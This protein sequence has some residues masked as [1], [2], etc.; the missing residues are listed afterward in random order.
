[1]EWLEDFDEAAPNHR[2]TTHLIALYPGAQITPR[3]TPGLAQAARVTLQRRL[4]QPNW[5]DVE[6]SRG[7][8]INFY[9]RLADGEAAHRHLLGLLR[10]DT[11]ANLLTFSRGGIA[12]APENIFVVDGNS[13][14]TA[15]LAEMLIQSHA[16]ESRDAGLQF[17]IEL[18]P[19]LPK[20]WPTGNVKGLRA[21]GGIEVDLAWKDGQVAE[22]HLRS[23]E[24][25]Q[26]NVRVRGELKTITTDASK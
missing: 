10:E 26:V 19:A 11:D 17:E 3:A 20:A 2:H 13:A 8:L 21:R 1:M 4:S 18:L 24:P 16:C 14:G 15:G 9:A 25:R 6:W 22:Y 23:R 12:G 5:E 7:N